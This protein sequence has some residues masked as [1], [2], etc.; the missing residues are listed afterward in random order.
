V[1]DRALAS[2]GTRAC[3]RPSELQGDLDGLR[4]R[5]D[6]TFA[7]LLRHRTRELGTA[8]SE[9]FGRAR[10]RLAEA[11]T[12][13]DHAAELLRARDFREA[14]WVLVGHADGRPVRSSAQ[15][16]SGDAVSLTFHDGRADTAVT[17][18]HPDEGVTTHA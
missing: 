9:L 15:L 4:E 1:L 2:A 11:L 6:K 17:A 13:L 16:T 14:G 3:R 8:R 12:R 18:T 7:R 10:R 5:A